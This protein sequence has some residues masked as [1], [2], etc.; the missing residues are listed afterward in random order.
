MLGNIL[1]D[2]PRDSFYLAT[3]IKP[4]GVSREGVP[5]DETTAEDFLAQFEVSLSRL[6]MD[7]VDILY[8]H[9]VRNPELLKYKPIINAMKNLKK[10][11]KAKFIGFSTHG[12]EPGV[13]DAAA[14]LNTFDVI[15]TAYNF[16]QTYIEDLKSAIGKATGAGIGI[17]AMKTLAGGGFLDKERTKPMNTTAAL[18]WVLSN[19]DITTT[20]PGMTDFDQL[21]L[22]AGV[23]A[24]ISLTEK[25]SQDVIIARAETGIYCNGCARCIPQC[26]KNLPVP[27]I[28]RAY[29]YAYGYSNTSMAHTLLGELKTGNDPCSDCNTC[30][31]KCVK[32]FNIKEKIAD[33]SRLVDVPADFLT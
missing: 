2:Y 30:S 10:D 26:P 32:N 23:L 20:I 18:K 1:K 17:I 22:N 24:D 4:A 13:I 15:L 27:D 29:M 16:K 6:R 3:K 21:D 7:Y 11:G 28:M 5:S 25:E 33:I 12:N 19:N 8:L 9:D 14:S 31:V